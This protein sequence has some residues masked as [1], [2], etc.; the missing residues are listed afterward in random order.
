ME[1]FPNLTEPAQADD[2]WRA[3]Y[4]L[5]FTQGLS[6][7]IKLK[8]LKHFG[9]VEAVFEA[10]ANELAAL[11]GE[12]GAAAILGGAA[13]AKPFGSDDVVLPGSLQEALRNCEQW[14]AC[15]IAR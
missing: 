4:R 5:A 6:Y 9:S 13:H 15:N 11:V 10:C 12:S 8:L 14:L 7:R 2:T 1:S 3:W